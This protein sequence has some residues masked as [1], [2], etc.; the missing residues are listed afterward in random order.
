MRIVKSEYYIQVLAVDRIVL[1][2]CHEE[3]A[4]AIS[5]AKWIAQDASI[6]GD[7]IRVICDGEL[8]WEASL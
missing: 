5:H 8:V 4:F 2:Q 3:R 7:L 6:E 1:E